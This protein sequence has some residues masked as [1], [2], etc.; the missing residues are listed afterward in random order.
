[1][2]ASPATAHE[3]RMKKNTFVPRCFPS[4]DVPC[5][6]CSPKTIAAIAPIAAIAVIVAIAAI[7]A[8]AVQ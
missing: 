8:T 3:P 4:R 6:L 2:W 7:A 1:M 5:I